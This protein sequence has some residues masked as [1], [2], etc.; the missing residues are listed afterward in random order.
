MDAVR[1]LLS[2]TGG[3]LLALIVTLSLTTATAHAAGSDT[4]VVGMELAYPPFEM[5]DTAGRAIGLTHA[6]IY[7][8]MVLP[9]PSWSGSSSSPTAGRSRRSGSGTR[10]ARI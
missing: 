6:Q 3:W 1:T 2:R 5:T 8:Y 9:R 4:L 7:R 10:R